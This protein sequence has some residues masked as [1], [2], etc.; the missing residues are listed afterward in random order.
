MA[1][2]TEA[3]PT[4]ATTDVTIEVI[5]EPSSVPPSVTTAK[6]T[7]VPYKAFAQ[8]SIEVSTE[9]SR[10]RVTKVNGICL[11][12]VSLVLKEVM[13]PKPMS[14]N[15][16]FFKLSHVVFCRHPYRAPYTAPTKPPA[17]PSEIV[18]VFI[19]RQS[20]TAQCTMSP[21]TTATQVIHVHPPTT[22]EA[23]KTAAVELEPSMTPT[24]AA[25][26]VIG[27]TRKVSSKYHRQAP[28]SYPLIHS[29]STS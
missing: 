17:E 27:T 14:T 10:V 28:S 18:F 29:I 16:I 20:S 11:E 1:T 6:A 8:P 12:I 15:K 3:A 25:T 13:S 5:K 23:I 26:R 24:E 7:K 19:F 2:S 22:T 9:L 4:E 21:R